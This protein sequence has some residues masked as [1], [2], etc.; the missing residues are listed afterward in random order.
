MRFSTCRMSISP[1]S[2]DSRLSR[3]SVTLT[4][5]RIFCFCSSLIGRCAAMVSARRPASSMPDSDVR[6]SGGIFLFSFTYWSNCDTMARRRASV[7]AD[8]TGAGGTGTASHMKCESSSLTSVIFARCVPSTSTFTV[9]S[10][11]F[12]ICRILAMQPTSYRSSAVGSSLAAVFWATSMMLLPDSIAVSS[13]LMDFGRPTN[14]GITM[15]GN[16]TTSRS[17]NSGRRIGSAGR[18]CVPDIIFPK[19]VI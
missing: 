18:S 3:R 12:S 16:T 13:A 7:S 8:S 10:G 1:S 19:S 15:C 14:S 5:S 6:I 9:P 11:S 2:C 4:I 17:G